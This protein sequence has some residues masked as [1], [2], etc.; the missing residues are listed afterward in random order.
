[1]TPSDYKHVYQVCFLIAAAALLIVL[2]FE[3]MAAWGN[4]QEGDTITEI[5][6]SYHLPPILFYMAAG[7]I[8]G[9]VIWAVRHLPGVEGL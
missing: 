7:V 6:Q 1:M 4:K 9:T 5:T 2:G 8:I 3:L